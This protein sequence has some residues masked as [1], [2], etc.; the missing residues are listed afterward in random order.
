M[1]DHVRDQ[2]ASPQIEPAQ[3][4]SERERDHDVGPSSCPMANTEYDK[5]DRS[6]DVTVQ[7]ERFQAF[8]GVTAVKQLFNHASANNDECDQPKRQ[9]RKCFSGAA[10]GIMSDQGEHAGNEKTNRRQDQSPDE[11][12]PPPRFSAAEGCELQA[13]AAADKEQKRNH[14]KPK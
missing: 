10:A 13:F 9:L 11:R 5:W 2:I 12:F 7:P 14:A 6:R 4:R 3:D 8:N 1:G